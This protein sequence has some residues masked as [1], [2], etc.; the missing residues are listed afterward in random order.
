MVGDSIIAWL[1]N[2]LATYRA[3]NV[4]NTVGRSLT[5]SSDV[6]WKPHVKRV[7][8]VNSDAALDADHY[9]VGFGLVVH[10]FRGSVMATS[11][12]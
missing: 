11:A 4:T 2:F 12:Q 1:E 3:A 8:K 9:V 5:N 6:I 7:Y 10:D